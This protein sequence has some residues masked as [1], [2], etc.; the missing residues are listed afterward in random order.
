MAIPEV[1]FREKEKYQTDAETILGLQKLWPEL[2][3][4]GQAGERSHPDLS[5]MW[6]CMAR[7]RAPRPQGRQ[8]EDPLGAVE[9]QPHRTQMAGPDLQAG[10][11]G[12]TTRTRRRPQTQ[13]S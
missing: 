8:E 9:F 1:I 6:H 4:A 10:T 3:L 11:L 5:T 7:T 13:E 12:T 2:D